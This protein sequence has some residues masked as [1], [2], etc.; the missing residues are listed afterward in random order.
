[1]ILKFFA[2][3]LEVIIKSLPLQRTSEFFRVYLLSSFYIWH[4]PLGRGPCY[5]CTIWLMI[6]EFFVY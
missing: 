2:E 6:G 5:F 1:M 4:G 3:V